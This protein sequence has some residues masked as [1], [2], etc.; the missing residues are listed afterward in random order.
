MAMSER[1]CD[2]G[3]M[4]SMVACRACDGVE[5]AR[6]KPLTPIAPAGSPLAPEAAPVVLSFAFSVNA[7]GVPVWPL[8]GNPNPPA[9]VAGGALLRVH[10]D[11][12]FDATAIAYFVSTRQIL[13]KDRHQSIAAA[14]LAAYWL[15]RALCGLSYP[16]IGALLRRDHT[17]VMSGVK[18]VER[19]RATDA[20]FRAHLELV[21]AA[22]R[23]DG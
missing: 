1:R 15:L 13:G 5:R 2:H 6:A 20:H 18:R 11:R 12:V 8:Q 19:R 14:R 9:V 3:F 7:P 21:A 22:A 16:Q 17:T 10:P 4:R 23:G